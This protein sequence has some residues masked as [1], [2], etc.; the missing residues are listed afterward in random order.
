M[1]KPDFWD[2]E[3]LS[4]VPRDARLTFIGMWNHSDDYGVVK[5]HPAWLKNKIF[6]Y[7]NIPDEKFREWLRELEAIRTII[8]FT[9]DDESFFHIRNFLKHQSINKPSKQRNPEPPEVVLTIPEPI[10]EDSGSPT[11]VLPDE[12]ETEVKRK[13]KK[14]S[15]A[16]G[17]DSKHY[18]INYAE[19]AEDIKNHCLL[20]KTKAAKQGVSFNPFAWVQKKCNENGHP[21][22]I[23]ACLKSLVKKQKT[24]KVANPWGYLRNGFKRANGNYN[25]ADAQKESEAFK[26]IAVKNG[27]FLS[28]IGSIGTP[29]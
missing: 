28:L 27:E 3:K 8:P 23:I 29:I 12:T 7:D 18:S 13:Q 1:I 17:S 16:S 20:I 25:E 14:T 4:R 15:P 24:E 26:N 22:A 9:V 19:V 6:P 11:G 10:P 21:H 2:D 5:G